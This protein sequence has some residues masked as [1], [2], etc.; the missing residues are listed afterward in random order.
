GEDREAV[1][2]VTMPVF[3]EPVGVKEQ[4]LAGPEP[5]TAGGEAGAGGGAQHDAGRVVEG[6][7][8]PAAVRHQGRGV[9]RVGVAEVAGGRV[10]HGVDGAGQHVWQE[11]GDGGVGPP[12][13]AGGV[14]VVD[15][16]A[17]QQ[18]AYL[19]HDRGG[20]DVVADDVARNQ[21]D[22]AALEGE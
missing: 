21:P 2:Y 10:D 16:V 12:E 17:A 15:R 3:D 5:P 14:G 11:A 4:P 20:G 13:H 9:P 6:L 7:G 22:Q 8:M 18:A 1:G 19:S